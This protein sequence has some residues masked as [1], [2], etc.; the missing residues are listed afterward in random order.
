MIADRMRLAV[1]AAQ[2]KVTP[3]QV[4]DRMTQD[5]GLNDDTPYEIA[6]ALGA[7]ESAHEDW[8]EFNEWLNETYGKDDAYELV[9]D[10]DDKLPDLFPGAEY[11]TRVGFTASK[12]QMAKID[13]NQIGIV[14]VEAKKSAK[15]EHIAEENELRFNPSD[16]RVVHEKE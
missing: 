7:P 4:L 2:N 6:G 8:D 16:L 5:A 3:E 9:Q 11:Q 12:K 10:L 13:P 1:D 14:K 15:P